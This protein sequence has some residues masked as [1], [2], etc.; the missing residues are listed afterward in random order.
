MQFSGSSAL[1]IGSALTCFV[2]IGLAVNIT[3]QNTTQ[4][5]ATAEKI[6]AQTAAKNEQQASLSAEDQTA[7]DRFEQGCIQPKARLTGQPMPL[8]PEI[9]FS[10]F[11]DGAILC[12]PLGK[13]AIVQNGHIADVAVV[14]DWNSYKAEK[15]ARIERNLANGQPVPTT[16]E[17]MRNN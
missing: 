6:A 12:D 2:A 15:K 10:V 1:A 17:I 8:T 16:E 5:K 4:Q 13:T 3:A 7:R 14:Q 11:G 9:D